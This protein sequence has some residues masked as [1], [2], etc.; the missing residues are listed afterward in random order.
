MNVSS[1]PLALSLLA[2]R[3]GAYL[4]DGVLLFGGV[5]LTQGL[6]YLIDANPLLWLIR[7]GQTPTGWQTHAW[8][9]STVSLPFCSI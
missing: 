8:V 9:F 7:A 5:L 4:I 2:R 3:L 6:L 1:S